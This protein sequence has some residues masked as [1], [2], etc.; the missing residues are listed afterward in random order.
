MKQKAAKLNFEL[1]VKNKNKFVFNEKSTN[2][3]T[4]KSFTGSKATVWDIFKATVLSEMKQMR[5]GSLVYTP[6]P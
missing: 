2:R 1:N 5:R 4:V 6:P 3:P